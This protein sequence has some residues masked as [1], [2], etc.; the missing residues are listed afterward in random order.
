VSQPRIAGVAVAA[1]VVLGTLAGNAAAAGVAPSGPVDGDGGHRFDIGGESPHITF[2]LH[3]DL[4]TNLGAAGDLGFSAVGTAMDTRVVTVDVQLQF[5]G[6]GPLEQFLRN[7]FSRFSVR[8]E[9]SLNIPWLASDGG[10]FSYVD[11]ETI[12]GNRSAQSPV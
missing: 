8:A 2:W 5:A 4:F 3:V 6:V 10:D 12:G 11:N 9:W 1:L 7:P